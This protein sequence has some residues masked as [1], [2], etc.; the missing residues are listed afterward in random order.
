MARLIITV[1][2]GTA[3][4]ARSGRTIQELEPVVDLAL[5]AFSP[6]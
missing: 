1:L 3:A 5:N 4:M 6:D 2:H